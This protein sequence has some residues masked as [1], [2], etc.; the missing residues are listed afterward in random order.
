MLRLCHLHAYASAIAGDAFCP[1]P[2]P[3]TMLPM[4][5]SIGIKRLIW[6]F[7][8]VRSGP[9][10]KVIEAAKKKSRAFIKQTKSS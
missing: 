4:P 7:A 10:L 5:L 8:G 3:S 9:Q 2:Q 6:D 1:L